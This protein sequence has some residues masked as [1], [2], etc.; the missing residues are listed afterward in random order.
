MENKTYGNLCINGSGNAGGGIYDNVTINGSGKITGDIECRDF[1]INGSGEAAGN[2]IAQELQISGS[3]R[4]TG[5]I[6]AQELKI[7][8]SAKIC[9]NVLDGNISIAGSADF[10]K[11]V[12]AK[13]V[14]IVGSVRIKGDCSAEHFHSDGA[15]TIG[16]LL[17]AEEV[18]IYLRSYKSSVR[19]IGGGK[20]TVRHKGGTG[21]ATIRN[22]L[23]FGLLNYSIETDS[24]EGDEIYLE[25]TK[26]GT[27]RGNNITIGH[28]CEI[29]L[30]EYKGT[31]RKDADAKITDERK[32]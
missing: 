11:N 23:S 9:G 13:R 27:V 14:K 7:N 29:G 10:E 32:V 16:G 31:L 5:D 2:L 15:F 25:N 28:G 3:G 12:N 19:E 20:I 1:S 8:G 24:I 30:V 22:I 26:A 6:S 4:I 18:D 21:A 17:N